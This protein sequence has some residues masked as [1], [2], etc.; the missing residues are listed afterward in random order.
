M[1]NGDFQKGNWV[2]LP[3]NCTQNF[4][5][6][7]TRCAEYGVELV[8]QC[9]L[10]VT[11]LETKCVEGVWNTVKK[12]SWW[13]W[14][15]CV[16]FAIVTTFVCLVLATIAITVCALFALVDI[17]VCLFWTLVSI[18]FCL[19]DAQGGTAF[20]LTDG[21]VMMQEFKSIDAYYLG[22]PL[23]TW[24]TRRW[25]RLTPDP[26]GSYEKGTWS[27]LADSN[28]ARAGFASA[29]LADGRVAICG[30]E[31]TDASGANA[32]D[33]NNTCEIYDPVANAWSVFA[34]PTIP[35]D[36]ATVWQYIGDAPSTLLPDG[37]LLVG[38]I[39]DRNIA[40]LDPT[41]LQWT[42]LNARPKVAS[43]TEDSWVLMPDNTISGPSCSN[44]P[45][46]WVY[47][48]ANDQWKEGEPL[49]TSPV[50]F[51]HE[52]G[53]GLLR[54]DGTAFFLGAIQHTANYSPTASPKWS[55]GP[56]MPNQDGVTIGIED[57]PAAV[58]VNGNI[59]F[60]AGSGED[61]GLASSPCWFFEY[62]GST[63]NRTNDPPNY[64]A[65]TFVSRL[66]LLPDGNYSFA[67]RTTRGFTPPF[68]CCDAAG[69]FSASDPDM[70]VHICG[71]E[72][73][74]DFRITVQWIVASGRVRIRLTDSYKL[75]AGEDH[76]QAKQS[77]ESIAGRSITPK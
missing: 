20:L 3:T 46:T 62:D 49:T 28:L 63:F 48:I 53:P 34:S 77:G 75:S 14:F 45:Q 36:S 18:A 7:Y 15:F 61:D 69:Q 2:Q 56:D 60:G 74:S 38:S 51:A 52:I 55:N 41:T 1:A 37:Q 10:H 32:P 21:T 12:C 70:P 76:E 25:W 13:S 67:G 39:M 58:L 6:T 72:H 22:V 64:S 71:G 33:D 9:V 66:L 43:S 30:G 8:M 4:V 44:A 16:L 5:L 73:D 17:V 31:Y 40:K 26:F 47:D 24:P 54:Y 35:G 68:R 42:A 59:L 23:L 57:G 19:S 27:R 50:N 65:F 29:V 11:E